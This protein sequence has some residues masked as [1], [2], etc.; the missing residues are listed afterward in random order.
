MPTPSLKSKESTNIDSEP[1]VCGS[2]PAVCGKAHNLLIS[3]Q[4]SINFTKKHSILLQFILVFY[5]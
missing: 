3:F 4:I 2:E 1:A 5:T